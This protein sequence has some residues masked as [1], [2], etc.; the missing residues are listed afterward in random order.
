MRTSVLGSVGLAAGSVLLALVGSGPVMAVPGHPAA[1][2]VP[3]G[4]AADQGTKQLGRWTV[5]PVTAGGYRLTWHS[6]THI[7]ITDAPVLVRHAGS[8]V[9]ASVS[10]SSRTVSVVV[11]SSTPPDPS[12]Y[13]VLLGSRVLDHRVDTSGPAT[14]S[15][16]PYRAP[17]TK[18]LAADD[19]GDP[20]THAIVSTNYKLDPVKL[21]DISRLSEM[22]GHVVAPADATDDSPLVLFLHGRHEACYTPGRSGGGHK[23]SS[24][25][26]SASK[27]DATAWTCPEGDKPVPSYLGYDYVQRLLASQG[28]VTVSISADA[29]NALDYRAIDGGA[30]ARATL[31]RDHLRAWSQFVADGTHPADLSNVVL[32]GH[33]RGGEGVNRASLDLPR[34][35]GYQVTGQVLIGPT[36][37]AF[38]AAPATPTVTLLPYCDGD[39]SDLQGQNFTDD[40][41]D[42]PT[43]PTT[44]LAFHSSVLVMGANH[45]FFNTEWTPGISA[46]PSFDD[47]GGS[48]TATC[49]TRNPSRLSAA[50]QRQVGEAYIAGAVHLFAGGDDSVLPMF[51]GSPVS[52]PSAGTAEIRTHAIGGGLVTVRPGLDG[53]PSAGATAVVRLCDGVSD[54]RDAAACQKRVSSGRTP[55]WPS[56][57]FAGVPHR[58]FLDIGWTSSG[59]EGGLDLDQTWDLSAD[60][61]LD[62]RTVVDPRRGPVR[63]GVKLT[64]VG[65]NS[66]VVTPVGGGNLYPL[67][68]GDYSLAKRWGQDLQVSLDA[69]DGIDLTQVSQVS[70]VAQNAS[71]RVYVA[72]ISATPVAGVSA[73]PTSDVPVFSIDT[74]KQPEGD[75]TDPVTVDV[76]WHVTGDLEQEATVTIVHS[77]P[78]SFDDSADTENIVI[79]AHTSSGMLQVTY[80]PND[81]DDRGKRFEGLTAYPVRGIET[82]VYVG[83]ASVVDDDPTPGVT[84]T[85]GARRIT[86]GQKATW[87]MALDEPVN[88]Y[89]FALLRPVKATSGPQLRVGDLTKRFRDR[90]FGD[91]TDLSLPLYKSPVRFFMQIRPH[92]LSR[93]FS[94]PTRKEHGD[95]RAISLRFRAQKF[96][97]LGHPVRTVRVVAP[98]RG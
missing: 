45:N 95:T 79:P 67:P 15:R 80:T 81:L 51:D 98:D 44:G 38:Q 77:T 30:A 86:A 93:T 85:T 66:T 84:I 11:P 2:G 58:Q 96:F 70:L 47:W 41:R 83:G 94:L 27:A 62:L 63:V 35:D 72:D 69:A 76:P 18:A 20:G 90:Y 14:T 33:S 6:P 52:V 9:T 97:E 54:S 61:R 12:T 64:D 82:D 49:G 17:S 42:V 73:D 34:D 8:S 71:G 23:T 10:A 26:P 1:A 28:Y 46:A 13:D 19:P 78:F 65:G 43:D 60:S 39:V 3:R 48:K 68:S 31:I 53:S 21:P 50:Q 25:A 59:Q 37:F 87:T 57:F 40:G 92:R 74:V 36:D 55:H 7:P 88:Y 22:V 56:E 75:G 4:A 29:I 16:T 5:S 89:A 91:D 32:V 24:A